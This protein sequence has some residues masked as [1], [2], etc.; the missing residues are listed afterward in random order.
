[1]GRVVPMGWYH[2]N[3]T[4][5]SFLLELLSI[6]TGIR[7]ATPTLLDYKAGS[8]VMD[9][10]DELVAWRANMLTLARE[11]MVHAQIKMT[12]QANKEGTDAT[13]DVGDWV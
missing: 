7:S 11:N 4:T 1:M 2:Y 3:T 8:T 13:F 12:Q 5:H 9:S 6:R 10:V